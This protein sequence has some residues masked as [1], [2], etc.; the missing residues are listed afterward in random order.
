MRTCTLILNQWFRAY[1]R[2][3]LSQTI[4]EVALLNRDDLLI[5]KEK[6]K[7]DPQLI[8]VSEWHPSLAKLPSMLKKHYHLLQSDQNLTE[9][10]QEPLLLPFDDPV[11]CVTIWSGVMYWL[12]AKKAEALKPAIRTNAKSAKIY[13]RREKYPTRK[14]KTP[15]KKSLDSATAS[16]KI[17]SMLSGVGNTMNCISD[18]QVRSWRIDCRNIDTT[19][20]QD[21]ITP[22]CPHTSTKRSTIQRK[23]WRS[24]YYKR[25]SVL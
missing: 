3:I 2:K 19:A 9:V 14:W 25:V 18:K 13:L 8:F 4:E 24:T 16:R 5:D 11:L 21:P 20:N 6:P 23:T 7:K 1:D 12:T 22:S 15:S 10:F 17:W